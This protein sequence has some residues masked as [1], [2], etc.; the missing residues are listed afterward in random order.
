MHMQSTNGQAVDMDSIS[1]ISI[2][3]LRYSYY[4]GFEN[5]GTWLRFLQRA[6]HAF[7]VV[8]RAA[9]ARRS[10]KRLKILKYK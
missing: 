5:E 7:Q 4:F 6:D 9:F 1:K 10:S 8:N 3:N 2:L